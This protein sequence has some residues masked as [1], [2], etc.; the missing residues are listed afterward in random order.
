MA[1][2][3]KTSI[4]FS[5]FGLV[6][7]A[8]TLSWYFWSATRSV[9]ASQF[10]FAGTDPSSNSQ[11]RLRAWNQLSY[12][13]TTVDF[14]IYSVPA[15]GQWQL[16]RSANNVAET[17]PWF[18]FYATDSSSA[19]AWTCTMVGNGNMNGNTNGGATFATLGSSLFTSMG[20]AGGI[21]YFPIIDTSTGATIVNVPVVFS[22]TS[23]SNFGGFAVTA[24]SNDVTRYASFQPTLAAPSPFLPCSNPLLEDYQAVVESDTAPLCTSHPSLFSFLQKRSYSDVTATTSWCTGSATAVTCSPTTSKTDTVL[25]WSGKDRAYKC[26][27]TTYGTIV[28]FSGSDDIPDWLRNVS[29][30]T[31]AVFSMSAHKGF[32]TKFQLWQSW[33]DTAASTSKTTFNGHSLGGAIANVAAVYWKNKYSTAAV[34]VVTN[35]A[36]SSFKTPHSAVYSA[37]THRRYVNKKAGCGLLSPNQRDQVTVV[38]DLLGFAHPSTATVNINQKTCSGWSTGDL[39]IIPIVGDVNLIHVLYPTYSDGARATQSSI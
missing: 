15:A 36:P 13:E 2:V 30:T 27:S 7:L 6:A 35:G 8:A 29:G 33:L 25:A 19:G 21:T 37:F 20:S 39:S 32:Y 34:S 11:I 22:A 1:S 14:E 10:Y 3:L 4:A 16:W 24:F 12:T 17:D 18:G 31:S 9:A 28:T 38:A 5:L 26:T 23:I